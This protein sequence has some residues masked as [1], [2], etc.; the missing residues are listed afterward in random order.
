VAAARL[1]TRIEGLSLRDA[2]GSMRGDKKAEAGRVKFV[3]LERVGRAIQRPVPDETVAET[4]A[5]AGFR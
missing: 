4:L 2:L 1:P 3:L 5:A